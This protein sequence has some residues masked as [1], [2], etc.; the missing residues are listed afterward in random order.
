MRYKNFIYNEER[1][2]V[3]AYVPKVACTNWKSLMRYMVG[4]E[5]WLD[6]KLAHD[7]TGSGLRFLDA[8]S[9]ESDVLTNPDVKKFAMVR[10]PY[11]RTLSAYL[12]K[13]EKRLPVRPSKKTDHFEK[14]VDE[15]EQ[16]RQ[17]FLQDDVY[18]EI[19]FEVFLLWLKYSK[20][21]HVGDEHWAP[22]HILLKQPGLRFD[23]I[24]RFEELQRD[25]AHI[26]S[27]IGCDQSFPSQKDVKFAPTNA[28]SKIDHYYTDATRTLVNDLFERDFQC[29]GY[30]KT[31]SSSPAVTRPLKRHPVKIDA[32]KK[33]KDLK[34]PV[35]SI[36][37][38]GVLNGTEELMQA[39]PGKHHILVEPVSEFFPA[40]RKKYDEAGLDYTLIEAAASNKDGT[41]RLRTVS[42]N[43]GKSITH[44]RM[45]NFDGQGDE[46]RDVRSRTVASIVSSGEF[47]GPFLLKVDVDGAEEMVMQG[48]ERVLHQC[49]VVCIEVGA[50]NF[51]DRIDLLLK[52]GFVLFDIV[53]LC[54]FDNRLAQF[55]F[56][57]VNKNMLNQQQAA[58]FFG[59][60]SAAKWQAYRP[61]ALNSNTKV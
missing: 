38:V 44:A 30:E 56:I 55:D 3:F 54:Y 6:N 13:V 51:F 39:Y 34:I 33:I 52:H 42:V 31:M 59:G 9:N 20:S 32:F 41:T 16:F 10:D 35:G 40:I 29:F 21:W 60:F 23:F 18:P 7:K 14:I 47:V 36:I 53:D 4:K 58:I 45:V 57:F 48:A 49:S 5:D 8:D 26:L 46:F 25:A 1:G 12:N 22:Q 17:V 37:D 43:Q 11:S 28:K 15:I 24:G 50:Q 2:F 27:E 61:N 19:N